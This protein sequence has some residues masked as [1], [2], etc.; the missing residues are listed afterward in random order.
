MA[1]RVALF[2]R[3]ASLLE[4]QAEVYRELAVTEAPTEEE[5]GRPR[6]ARGAGA[7]LLPVA[8][9]AEPSELAR[10]AARRALRGAAIVPRK[11]GST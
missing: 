7:L 9:D 4:E 2:A 5:D 3:L 6:R 8:S 11:R 10:A 1:S